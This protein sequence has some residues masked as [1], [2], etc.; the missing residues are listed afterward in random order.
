MS[1]S[2]ESDQSSPKSSGS[3]TGDIEDEYDENMMDVKSGEYIINGLS[4]VL[5]NFTFLLLFTS[6]LRILIIFSL[7]FTNFI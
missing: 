4:M 6:S 3:N 5:L 7:C 1:N 2:V